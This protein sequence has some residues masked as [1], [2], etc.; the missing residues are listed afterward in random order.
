MGVK[1]ELTLT[2]KLKQAAALQQRVEQA[3]GWMNQL[4]VCEATA[5]AD[6]H[7][8]KEQAAVLAKAWATILAIEI[9]ALERERDRLKLLS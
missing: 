5:S 1:H 4:E 2:Q 3:Q 9:P 6:W 8:G 7:P